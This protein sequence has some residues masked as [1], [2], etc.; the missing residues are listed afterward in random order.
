M[1]EY[2]NSQ[3]MTACLDWVATP[4]SSAVDSN[5]TACFKIDLDSG[6]PNLCMAG[7]LGY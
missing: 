4:P 6:F 5:V 1:Y 2:K 3:T 7:F